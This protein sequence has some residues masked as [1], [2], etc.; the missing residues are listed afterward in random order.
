MQLAPQAAQRPVE[1]ELRADEVVFSRAGAGED[2]QES[3]KRRE[4]GL[5]RIAFS[6]QPEAAAGTFAGVV[7]LERLGGLPPS[8]GTPMA[9]VE[10]T[11]VVRV[12]IP[13]WPDY[14]E[15]IAVSVAPGGQ[16]FPVQK[17]AR[18]SFD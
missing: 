15:L 2:G 3:L 16:P 1:A 17:T 18:L 5:A 14:R 12:R 10:W 7:P 11:L 4:H 13:L 6:L 9:R 8:F